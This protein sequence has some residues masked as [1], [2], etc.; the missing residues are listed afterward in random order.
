MAVKHKKTTVKRI[1][2]VLINFIQ[3]N[4]MKGSRLITQS[5]R[6]HVVQ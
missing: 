4:P 6:Y 2:I 1:F 5:E 3:R